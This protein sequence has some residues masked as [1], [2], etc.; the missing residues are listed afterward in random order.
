MSELPHF[1]L[2]FR[3]LDQLELWHDAF[4]NLGLPAPPNELDILDYFPSAD[5]ED[6]AVR[7]SEAEKQSSFIHSTGGGPR[8]NGSAS[9]ET[10]NSCA[11]I[12]DPPLVA[13]MHVPV[14]LVVVV[15]VSSSAQGAK[16]ALL[17]NALQF[18]VA[19]LGE[20]DRMGVVTY[21]SGGDAMPIVGMTS[22]T[23]SG[24]PEVY[25]MVK[26]TGQID[27]AIDV[28]SSANVAVDLL[29]QRTS[30]NALASIL[31]VSDSATLNDDRVDSLVLRAEAAK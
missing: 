3:D 25:E 2:Q 9:T 26:P 27:C 12:Q 31:L 13:S 22:K 21:G 8:S 11:D 6:Y 16:F 20:H 23:W 18:L 17:R 7:T 5:D 15:P 19:N 4:N 30:S 24:W 28:V 14:D 10:M 1:H 29:L